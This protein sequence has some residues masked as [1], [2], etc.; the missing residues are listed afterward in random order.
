MI[1]QLEIG[2]KIDTQEKVEATAN[3]PANAKI[4]AAEFNALPAKLNEVITVVN[5]FQTAS[6]KDV[7][8]SFTMPQ[9]TVKDHFPV[10]TSITAIE[11]NGAATLSL[12]TNGGATYA[13]VALP[14]GAPIVLNG[15]VQWRITYTPGVVLAGLNYKI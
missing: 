12:S 1:N 9:N 15:W 11:L 3:I 7:T 2:V 14:L 8:F 13:A 6:A 5:D 4:T 10:A